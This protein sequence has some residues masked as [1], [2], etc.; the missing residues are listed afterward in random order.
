V[1]ADGSEPLHVGLGLASGTRGRTAVAA[2]R[3]G[4]AARRELGRRPRLRK[5]YND[6]LAPVRRARRRLARS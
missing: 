1:L 5:A 6:G 3:A 2:R 4:L